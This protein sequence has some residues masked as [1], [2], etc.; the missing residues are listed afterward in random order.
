VIDDTL[1]DTYTAYA[2]LVDRQNEDYHNF[3]R[4]PGTQHA[5]NFLLH[6]VCF[7]AI[8]TARALWEEE[9]RVRL[10]STSV[11]LHSELAEMKNSS[12]PE[13]IYRIALQMTTPPASQ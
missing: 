1:H 6:S 10:V 13:F 5:N 8:L 7:Y 3:F 2:G 12:V 11:R 4:L 9:R